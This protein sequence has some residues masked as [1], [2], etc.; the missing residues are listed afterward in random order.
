MS[1]RNPLFSNDEG[2]LTDAEGSALIFLAPA[3]AGKEFALRDV[4][5]VGP[6][7]LAA[8]T[9][10]KHLTICDD[11]DEFD[12]LALGDSVKLRR[13]SVEP[14][15]ECSLPFVLKDGDGKV[16]PPDEISGYTYRLVKKGEFVREGPC[17]RSVPDLPPGFEEGFGG[18]FGEMK[19][20]EPISVKGCGFDDVIGLDDVKLAV[21]RQLI[22][23]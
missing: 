9:S 14:D 21:R 13:I 8:C 19:R 2:M 7:S 18:M 16:L 22:L 23:P 17:E 12:L 10:M 11:I 6:W 20:F 4:E 3:R 5:R 1:I 15:V